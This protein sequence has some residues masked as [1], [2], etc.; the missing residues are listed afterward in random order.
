MLQNADDDISMKITFRIHYETQWGEE[1]FVMGN[2]PE[3]GN[4]D[5]HRACL[6][7]Y[8]EGAIW[9]VSIET[10]R[11]LDSLEYAYFVAKEHYPI[12][13]EWGRHCV[14]IT[15]S[16]EFLLLIDSWQEKPS[17]RHLTSKA[18]TKAFFAHHE[19]KK[20]ASGD[21]C[22][23][24]F[25]P[26]VKQNDHLVMVGN[27]SL[28]GE[29]S[30]LMA[31]KM[32]AD[33]FPFWELNVEYQK[34]PER[35]EFKFVVITENKDLIW[36]EGE[37]RVIYPYKDLRDKQKGKIIQ[38]EKPVNIPFP[39]WKG[40]GTAIPLFSLRSNDS[41]GVGD[42]G[43]LIKMIDWVNLTGQSMIQLLPIHDTTLTKSN[44]DSYPYSAIS[45]FAIHPIYLNITDLKPLKAKK[46]DAKLRVRAK[47]LNQL[48]SLDYTQ[49][50]QL[51]QNFIDQYFIENFSTLKEEQE[52]KDFIASEKYWIYDYALFSYYRDSSNKNVANEGLPPFSTD[53]LFENKN[54]EAEKMN[55]INKTL[56]TQFLLCRQ[57]KQAS[58][59][60]ESKGIAIKGDIPIGID[61]ISVE[62]W[63]QPKLF[64]REQQAG[65]PPDYFSEKGQNWGFPTY[66]WERMEQ[67]NFSWWHKRLAFG[68]QFFHAYRIDHILGFFRIWE[69][70]DDYIDA[71]CGHF[72]PA[73]PLNQNEILQKGFILD[74]QFDCSPIIHEDDVETIFGDLSSMVVGS[75]LKN[76]NHCYYQLSERVNTQKKVLK[77]LE[78]DPD[79]VC[80]ERIVQGLFRICNEVLF[81]PD[82]NNPELFHP[83][84]DGY[85]TLR[86]NRLS[87]SEKRAFYDIHYDF[88]YKRH[89]KFWKNTAIRRLKPIL[90]ETDLL[91]CA[92]DLGMLPAS[93]PEVLDELQIASLD[94]ERMPKQDGEKFGNPFTF[95]YLSVCTT[96]THDMEPLRLWWQKYPEDAAFYYHQVLNKQDACPN[97]LSGDL[98]TEI[99]DRNLNSNSMLTILPLQDWLAMD[100]NIRLEDPNAERINNPANPKH[101]WCYRMHIDIECLLQEENLNKKII[102]LLKKRSRYQ[103]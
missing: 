25:A 26:Q 70:P 91:L 22:F 75:Y 11:S 77:A 21:Y 51:K 54:D 62:A 31:P 87:D 76:Y 90:E 67:D 64:N 2:S 57:L 39:K 71:I 86:F 81:I 50:L 95:P 103:V 29:W 10:S 18:F 42:F 20:T 36:E 85:K 79:S 27:S 88:F 59:Y 37:N 19:D 12:K 7:N 14:S 16:T 13:K 78:K 24:V 35:L 82:K 3:L 58:R 46:I 98:A 23:R 40:S 33:K 43:D 65:A 102:N 44:E 100:E 47:E 93:V 72:N 5:P 69:I 68:S 94:L 83:R 92:E 80:K 74:P 9:E 53:L 66:N 6:M 4:N 17:M 99:I 41:W 56:M 84:I 28:F 89:N 30:P 45:I 101:Y 8:T 48:P 55:S 38:T 49:V 34:L 52:Y 97:V 96:S 15:D 32:N 1:L 63:S 61:P 60:A 73:L